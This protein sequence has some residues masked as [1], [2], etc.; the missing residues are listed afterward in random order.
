MNPHVARLDG[1]EVNERLVMGD[2][3]GEE[4]VLL[5]MQRREGENRI[6]MFA[7]MFA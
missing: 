2:G 3:D 7:L 6:E 5:N 1:V 4:K